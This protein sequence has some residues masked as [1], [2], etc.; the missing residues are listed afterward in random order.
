MENNYFG[1]DIVEGA[2]LDAPQHM[3]GA[4]IPYAKVEAVQRGEV[5]VPGVCVLQRF[6]YA[7]A[8]EYHVRV[9]FAAIGYKSAMYALP[10]L[11]AV[12]IGHGCGHSAGIHV[13]FVVRVF[14]YSACGVRC[15]NLLN[16]N[17]NCLMD[18]LNSR[19]SQQFCR[20]TFSMSC[21]KQFV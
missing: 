7:I 8:E 4:I 20:G 15:C 14:L 6:E 5:L 9:L 16:K 11:V 19:P 21:P 13:V 12:N 10:A 17:T 18:S 2:I 1:I 3:L